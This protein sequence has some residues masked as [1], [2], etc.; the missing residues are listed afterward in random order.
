MTTP[1]Y[2]IK[3]L[4]T[5]RIPKSHIFMLA[6]SKLGGDRAGYNQTWRGAVFTATRAMRDGKVDVESRWNTS[7]TL[8]WS[9]LANRFIHRGLN[10]LWCHDLSRTARITGMLK[11]LP[12]L[13]FTM[14]AFNLTPGGSWMSWKR[15]GV[16]LKVVDTMSIWPM[17]IERVA[18]LF[19]SQLREMPEWDERDETWMSY[20]WQANKVLRDAAT[21]YMAWIERE[22]LGKLAVTGNGQAFTAYRRRFMTSGILVHH[23][24]DARAMEREAAYTGRCEAMYHGPVMGDSVDEWDF[25]NAHTN[26]GLH[27][28][29]PVWPAFPVT[30]NEL[31]AYKFVSNDQTVLAEVE[32]ETDEPVVPCR[33]DGRIIWPTGKFVSTLWYPELEQLESSGGRYRMLKGCVYRTAPVL[34]A[35]AAWILGQLEADDSAVPAWRKTILK[36][37]GNVLVGRFGM[38]YPKWRHI[39]VSTRSDAFHLPVVYAD[40]DEEVA[41]AQVG[42]D[43]F[44]TEGM[45]EP[46]YAAPMITSYIMSVMRAKLWRVLKDATDVRVLY[47]DTDSLLV[48]RG[49]REKMQRIAGTWNGENLRLKRS[50]DRVTILG[51]RQVVADGILKVAGLPGTAT[52]LGDNEF[53]AEVTESLLQSLTTLQ[54]SSV[55]SA[56]RRFSLQGKDERRVGHRIGW[57]TPIHLGAEE[58]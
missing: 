18:A 48:P 11:A 31:S 55:R 25:S 6:V 10:F 42:Y 49:D 3:P 21:S 20:A 40:T 30:G 36:R 47:V 5:T 28:N 32:I 45:T 4:T 15:E 19:G 50:W 56:I 53:E 26:I 17:P 7:D 41:M 51:P 35:W 39:G 34:S 9:L 2:G 54:V 12:E 37:W 22:D 27:Y 29:V 58:R 44:E 38:R 1:D 13:G 33:V 8:M 24:E 43:L 14:S 57:T 23:N 16:T 52:P 46:R